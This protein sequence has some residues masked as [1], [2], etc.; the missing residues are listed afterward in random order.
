[1][2]RNVVQDALLNPATP[3][4][5]PDK[6]TF[7]VLLCS[8][9]EPFRQDICPEKE[10]TQTKNTT[11][12][13][14]GADSGGLPGMKVARSF[15]LK[16]TVCFCRSVGDKSKQTRPERWRRRLVFCVQDR[17]QGGGTNPV[18]GAKWAAR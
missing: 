18:P 6:N 7:D 11:K 10:A 14:E 5:Y 3:P 9:S 15:T 17:V 16:Q 8:F 2:S 12:V 1:M 4:F 13:N